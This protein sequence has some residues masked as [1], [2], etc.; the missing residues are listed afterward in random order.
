[1]RP[2]AYSVLS[3]LLLNPSIR[4]IVSTDREEGKLP[5]SYSTWRAEILAE[6]V[7]IEVCMRIPRG[8]NLACALAFDLQHPDS[9]Q[10]AI[11]MQM[12]C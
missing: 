8:S 3:L 6:L 2:R 9:C 11:H 10:I 5:F 7:T 4:E 1:M 12:L